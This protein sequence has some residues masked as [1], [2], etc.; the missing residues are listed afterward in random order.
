MVEILEAQKKIFSQKELRGSRDR[1]RGGV[2]GSINDGT[3]RLVSLWVV[4]V[5]SWVLVG[6][7]GRAGQWRGAGRRNEDFGG[8]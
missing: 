5:L 6:C 3:G 7:G 4:L 8:P 1:S 2:Y